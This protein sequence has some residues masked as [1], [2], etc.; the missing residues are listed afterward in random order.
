L[1]FFFLL[2]KVITQLFKKSLLSF[3]PKKITKE[4][5]MDATNALI[6]EAPFNIRNIE[7]VMDVKKKQCQAVAHERETRQLPFKYVYL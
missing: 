2:Y 3:S 7:H 1:Y 4:K 5:F 6:D